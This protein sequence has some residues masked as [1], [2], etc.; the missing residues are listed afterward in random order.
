[1]QTDAQLMV[2]VLRK[3]QALAGNPKDPEPLRKTAPKPKLLGKC[4]PNY[5]AASDAIQIEV[6]TTKGRF[7]TATRDIIAGETV[8]IETPYSSVL[9]GE[10]SKTHCQNCF[11]K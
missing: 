8:L 5:P 7:A 10:F 3:G 2:E 4:N 6:D 1:M 11:V 9:L